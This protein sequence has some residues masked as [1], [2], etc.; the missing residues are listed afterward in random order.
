MKANY[1]V[2]KYLYHF[3]QKVGSLGMAPPCCYAPPECRGDPLWSPKR[4]KAAPLGLNSV[5]VSRTNAGNA[6]P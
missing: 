5:I 4:K 6:E 3:A 1:I 2:R